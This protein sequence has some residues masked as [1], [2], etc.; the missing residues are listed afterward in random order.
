MAE[1][2]NL[3]IDDETGDLVRRYHI[4]VSEVARRALREEIDRRRRE[5]LA[6]G[7]RR[8]RIVLADIPD[9]EIVKAGSR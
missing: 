6:E 2:H 4:D 5:E 9:L 8:A 7:L 3:R 1:L